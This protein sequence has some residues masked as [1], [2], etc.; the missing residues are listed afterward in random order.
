MRVCVRVHAHCKIC[1]TSLCV[2]ECRGQL[3]GQHD[4]TTRRGYRQLELAALIIG[5]PPLLPS[6]R[7]HSTDCPSQLFYVDMCQDQVVRGRLK[8]PGVGT[9]VLVSKEEATA[10]KELPK[11][12]LIIFSSS[13]PFS[14]LQERLFPES[15]AEGWSL[16][17]IPSRGC[18]E[19][20]HSIMPR[21]KPFCWR[22]WEWLSPQHAPAV[23]Q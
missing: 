18:N 8:N 11:E 20:H 15:F 9:E 5:Q 13:N 1:R 10:R 14:S 12:M 3:H 6:R 22:L 17:T 23:G 16:I 4:K 7:L 21:I 2:S 19:L